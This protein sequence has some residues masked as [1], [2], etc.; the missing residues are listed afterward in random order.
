MKVLVAG[1]FS[2][3]EMG[4]TAG[5]LLARDVVC[6]WLDQAGRPYD[7]AVAPPFT[8]GIDWRAVD[9]AE[10][11]DLVFVCG[12]FGNGWPITEFLP[13]FAN[14]RLLGV[15]LSML[16]PLDEWNPFDVLLERDS[17]RAARP[18]VTFLSA[19]PKVPVVGLI[20]VHHQSEY[21]SGLHEEADA[22]LER[23]LA[24]RDVAVVRIDTR[25]DINAT[26]LHT[27]A[28][29]ESAI[30]RMD[31]VVTTRLHGL[32][33]ALK[34]GVPV[35]AVDAVAGGAKVG[36]QAESI[37]WPHILRAGEFDDRE[38]LDALDACLAEETRA[39][40]ASCALRAGEA[41]G[42]VRAQLIEGL[43]ER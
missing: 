23:A 16:Q 12:P 9:P 21:P 34:N 6:D 35:V 28:Q 27:P 8:D 4:A 3:E 11:S 25:L 32:V 17:S 10:Y 43:S 22:A 20:L 26:G 41:L 29:V 24:A 19:A 42:D 40:A 18:D 1:W 39:L 30:A 13:R 38:L 15:D 5:D 31:V 7:V 36:R 14:C 33:L 37:G 2:F